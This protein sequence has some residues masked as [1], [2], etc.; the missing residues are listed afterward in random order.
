[1]E[2][3]IRVGIFEFMIGNTDWAAS[4]LHNIKLLELP[5]AHRIYVPH[6]FD[7]SGFVGT[8]Y[9]IP[10]PALGIADVKQRL[11]MGRSES[12]EVFEKVLKEF[13]SY[14][15]DFYKLIREFDLLDKREKKQTL[16]YL[17][18]FFDLLKDKPNLII[19]LKRNS[20]DYIH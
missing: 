1:M 9:A 8:D 15:N 18:E 17:D 19:S 4:V 11:Y 13:E 16:S 20:K 3:I 14:K 12:D 2:E 10:D 5:D 6:D 7:Y